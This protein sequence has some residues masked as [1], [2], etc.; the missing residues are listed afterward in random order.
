M[1]YD[2]KSMQELRDAAAVALHQFGSFDAQALGYLVKIANDLGLDE[3]AV[4]EI[5]AGPLTVQDSPPPLVVRPKID[6]HDTNQPPLLRP[7]DQVADQPS[8]VQQA[9][10]DDN[11]PPLTPKRAAPKPVGE[12]VY[13]QFVQAQLEAGKTTAEALQQI[14]DRG[15]ATFKVSRV[16]ARHLLEDMVVEASLDIVVPG[17][18]GAVAQP[19]TA[20]PRVKD[21]VTRARGHIGVEGGVNVK[22]RMLIDREAEDLNLT[23]AERELGMGILTSALS[24]S[25]SREDE[26]AEELQQ[27]LAT[28]LHDLSGV[29]QGSVHESI[30]RNAIACYGVTAETASRVMKEV[31]A[32]YGIKL[33]SRE[34]VTGLLEQM[35]ESVVG[36]AGSIGSEDASHLREQAC[37]LG[38][39]V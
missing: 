35:C 21:F 38:L 30:H 26:R 32:G 28:Q 36:E 39:T 14:L 7:R 34:H 5:V 8:Q 24:T 4:M 6:A 25:Q 3:N 18:K 15:R 2:P 12:E 27:D 22:S 23:P 17:S 31:A 29:V 1:T 37:K 33:F 9:S 19:T 11:P 20:E 16:F 10:N 13:K